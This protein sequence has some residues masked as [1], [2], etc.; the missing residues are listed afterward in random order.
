ML[1]RLTKLKNLCNIPDKLQNQTTGSRNTV[2]A[3]W[4]DNSLLLEPSPVAEFTK[5]RILGAALGSQH[6]LCNLS[7]FTILNARQFISNLEK[8]KILSIEDHRR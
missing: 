1:M 7:H 6:Q 3:L 5:L 8:K 4:L 2:R